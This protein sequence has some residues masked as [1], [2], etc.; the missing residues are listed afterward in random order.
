MDRVRLRKRVVRGSLALL[1]VPVALWAF[2]T[3]TDNFGTVAPG[4]IYRAGQM[5]GATLARTLA[6][7]RVRTV[8]NLRGPNPDQAWYRAER[9]ATI[10]AGA[11]Q[12][13][14]SLSSCEWMSHAQLRT[15][16]RVLDTSEYPLLVH[17]QYGS[18]RT[19][20]VSAFAELLRPGSTLRDAEAQFT[21]RHLFLPVRD[22]KMMLD[23][24]AQ[25]RDWLKA[26]GAEHSP[27]RFRRWADEGYT[28]RWPT[29]EMWPYD[30]KPLVV[31][32]RPGPGASGDPP[33]AG[34]ARG[35]ER[36]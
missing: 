18:E 26:Q 33:L 19:G 29:R 13:D 17:C 2:V 28:P 11:T 36:R 5:G 10:A 9:A 27:G 30:P 7:Y 22:G 12:V 8:L 4:R 24:L 15:L 34:A 31:I 23:H 6:G 25:Y 1:A 3:W 21:V 32:T 14:L 20:L 16:I 35:V